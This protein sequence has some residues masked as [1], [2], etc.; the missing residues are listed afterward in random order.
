MNVNPA[1]IL[2]FIAVVVLVAIVGIIV[3][4]RLRPGRSKQSPRRVGAAAV[5]LVASSASSGA[6]AGCGGSSGGGS[7]A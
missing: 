2:G 5:V 6:A 3:L 7:C 4:E 1:V